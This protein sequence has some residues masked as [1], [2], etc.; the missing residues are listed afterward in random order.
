MTTVGGTSRRDFLKTGVLAGAGLVIGVHLGARRLG[1][2]TTAM[3]DGDAPTDPF[4]PNAWL[5]IT[6]DGRVTVLLDK[7]E[8]GQGVMTSLPMIVAEELD[9]DWSM[10]RSEH[11]TV[12]AARPLKGG[13]S[14]G[15]SGSVRGSWKP[16]REAGASARLML[17]T[18]AAARWQ[19]PAADC[20]TENGRVIHPATGRSLG[21]GDVAE[22][23]ARLPV[24]EKPALKDPRTFRFIGRRVPRLDTPPKVDGTAKFG[25]DTQVPGML[26]AVVA[27]CAACGGRARRVDDTR[28]RVL[29]GV[30]QVVVL[31]DGGGVAVIADGYWQAMQGRRA[32]VVEWEEPTIAPST[33]G[34]VQQLADQAKRPG[35]VSH[36]AGT[37][38]EV[39]A[40]AGTRRVDAEYSLPYLAHAA[41]EPVNC[42][43]SVTADRCEIW[44]PTQNQSA[45]MASALATTGLPAENI[46]LHTTMLGGGFGRRLEADFVAEACRLSKA[47]GA[48][49]KV[50]WSRE[51]DVQHDFYRPASHHALSGAVDGEG[52]PTAW[53]HRIVGPS[54][55][56]RARPGA[57]VKGLDGDHLAGT[58]R[59]FS[60]A[61]ANYSAEYGLAHIPVPIGW[62]R[63][64]GQSQNCFVI[65]SFIDELAAAGK[66]DPVALRRHLLA[67]DDRLRGVVELA[68][69]KAGWG[70]KLPA[71]RGRGIAAAH[72]FGSYAAE[73]AEVTVGRDGTVR[74]DRVVC[75]VDCGQ[76]V[77]PDTAESQ[78]QG[79][80]LYGLSAA[81]YGEITLDAGRVTQ[82]NFHDYRVLRMREAPPVEVY[83][84]ASTEAPGGLGEPGVPPIAPAVANAIFAATGQRVRKLP[85]KLAAT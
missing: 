45:A 74:V 24:P 21:Y 78:V 54:I 33:P 47:A 67:A 12:K 71:G 40:A 14:T 55:L 27:R 25:I 4:A 64:V 68:A 23:A 22:D 13:R 62:W 41:M 38:A 30:R 42:T 53:T 16:L 36:T 75:A 34:I 69:E 79:G 70:S 85:I 5:R 17:I 37:P 65:E 77:N 63:S 8:M 28:A 9:A 44:A 60:Y 3:M 26:V 46:V 73:V 18:A 82:S 52:W 31:P 15:G 35:V 43:A 76:V 81:L 11:A 83:F 49:V 72:A 48:P 61:I 50:V 58:G 6:P 56:E 80:V 20:R 10:V 29:P 2:A 51:D 19:V 39:L 59:E 84:V 7:T 1:G 57:L 32:L 66:K